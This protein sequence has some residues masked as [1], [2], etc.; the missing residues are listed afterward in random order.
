MAQQLARQLEHEFS[1]VL[2][3]EGVQ[4]VRDGRVSISEHAR[5]FLLAEVE[6]GEVYDV[7]VRWSE[8]QVRTDAACTCRRFRESG[9]CPHLWAAILAQAEAEEDAPLK[10]ADGGPVEPTDWRFR[11]RMLRPPRTRKLRD[12]WANIPPGS[13]RIVF[14][15]GV[16]KTLNETRVVLRLHQE[17]RLRNGRFGT[18]K[19]LD[20]A[21]W[22]A[23]AA[24]DPIDVKALALL[25][26]TLAEMPA[27]GS[28]RNAR[29]P[30]ALLDEAQ[31][32]VLL[33]LLC[34]SGRLFL[35]VGARRSAGALAWD[36]ENLWDLRFELVR[37]EELDQCL[38]DAQLVRGERRIPLSEPWLFLGSSWFFLEGALCRFRAH[39]AGPWL[40]SI[41][42]EGPL[43]ARLDEES[44]LLHA[45]LEQSGTPAVVAAGV[46]WAEE[47]PPRPH[48]WVGRRAGGS[49]KLEARV[50]FDYAGVRV[51][52]SDELQVLKQPAAEGALAT[53]IR[54]DLAAESE[55]LAQLLAVPGVE[56]REPDGQRDALVDPERLVDLVRALLDAGWAVD[57]EGLR[58]R[59]S[60]SL[61]YS[62]RTGLD[63]FDLQ[64]GLD[65]EGETASF[66]ALLEAAREKRRTVKLGDGSIGILP[67]RWLEDWK[68][69]EALGEEQ[70]DALRFERSQ[71][72]VLDALLAGRENVELDAGFESLRARIAGFSGVRALEEP[73]GF[74]GELRSYQREALGWLAFLGELGFG[75]CLADDMGLGKTVQV[76]AH[77]LRRKQE[78]GETRTCLVVTP[79]SLCF[80][81][82]QEAA[83]FTPG[84]SVIEYTGGDRQAK[85]KRL[86]Q[87]DIV[88]TTY[89]T[90]R[91]DA[92]RL[93]KIRF[94]S[95][96]LDEAQAIKNPASQS[97][98]AA[99]LL[100]AERRLALSGTP[101]ENHLGDLWSI[102][103]F[104]NPGMLGRLGALREVDTRSALPA[105]DAQSLERLAR[106]LRP[107]FLRR[108]KEQVLSDLPEKTEQ[109]LLCALEGRQH[110]EY[111][112]LREH[113]RRTL[114]GLQPGE[115]LGV[116]VLTALLRLRQAACHP[117]LLDPA[118][119]GDSSAKLEALLGMLEDAREGGHKALVF[120]QFTSLLAIVRSNLDARGLV[121][122]YLDGG[123]QDREAR[124]RRFQ[125]DPD[126]P[127][128]LISLKAGGFGLNL[129]A[130][131]YVF[132]LDPW[133]N[134]AVETQAIDRAHRIGQT[135][136]VMAYRIVARGTI[137]ERVLELQ[138]KK[139]GLAEAILREDQGGM[140]TLT[141]ED[142]E[143]LL[144]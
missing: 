123:T 64:G 129:T 144:S 116:H 54:R 55:R 125:E 20:L 107:F 42:R 87:H 35:E 32:E 77:L 60:G 69:F 118:R 52:A 36:A 33:P 2:R 63:W 115:G 45:L 110:D 81:W 86:A 50:S 128:F 24:R 14:V 120:S 143:L 88:V 23:A 65:F 53:L 126:C 46:R 121:Y 122:E 8:D 16:D 10:S 112:E 73:A 3:A 97:A 26:G 140:G 56:A 76:L 57:A 94:D 51:R 43:R 80:H 117:G 106:A 18:R 84:L 68:L 85:W 39:G 119:V 15:V 139:R 37:D 47:A 74:H 131:D 1:P 22:G 25:G 79:R 13:S 38:L 138:E 49:A 5:G 111:E 70:D 66:P 96:V 130:A 7:G 99:R 6:D 67:E 142:L 93:S 4:L 62:V 41:R 100:Q 90:L 29:T 101:V 105:G 21:A 133:W 132:L 75:G 17:K 19:A 58:W 92:E 95:V 113:F 124:V 141:R 27:G 44:E 72:W 28:S 61:R 40:E 127:F 11:L 137:E 135:R 78:L 9:S 134:P 114:S 103:E 109:T 104:L 71:G 34:Q 59:R 48:L 82:V 89:G 102:F 91:Q 83:R 98:K 108:T 136:R 30:A 12:P 31:A